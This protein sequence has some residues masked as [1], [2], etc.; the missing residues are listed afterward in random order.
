MGELNEVLW[1]IGSDSDKKWQSHKLIY[2]LSLSEKAE[3]LEK[4]KE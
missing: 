4:Y 2:P 1:V 3:S